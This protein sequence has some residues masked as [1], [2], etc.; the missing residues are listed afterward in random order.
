MSGGQTTLIL[1]CKCVN[2][3]QD[4]MYGL[5]RRVHNQSTRKPNEARCSGCGVFNL[6]SHA[7]AESAT[8]KKNKKEMKKNR[9]KGKKNK[10]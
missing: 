1:P 8:G 7:F 10:R 2:P 3:G 6:I 9:D 5:G 4:R